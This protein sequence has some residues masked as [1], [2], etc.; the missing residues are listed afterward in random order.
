MAANS[1]GVWNEQSQEYCAHCRPA[2]FQHV[3]VF[4]WLAT[5]IVASLVGLGYRY[6]LTQLKRAQAAQQA[7]S[8]QL[9]ARRKRRYVSPPNCTTA[10][11]ESAD[12]Q[13]RAQLGQIAANGAPRMLEQ[14][15]WFVNSAT[16]SIEE[17]SRDCT[18]TCGLIIWIASV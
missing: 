14:F 6:P 7:F 13:N 12:R 9:I 2:P 5:L 15:E 11:A 8:R 17:S 3:V 18:K 4:G 1:D 16:E 10:W